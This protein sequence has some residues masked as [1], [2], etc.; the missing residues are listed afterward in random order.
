MGNF[1]VEPSRSLA[2]RSSTLITAPSISQGSCSRLSLIAATWASISGIP[3][4]F[5]YG[6]TLKRSFFKYSRVSQWLEKETPSASW[7]LKTKI[8]SPRLAAIFGSSCRKEPAA[9]FRGLANNGFPSSSRRSFSRWKVFLGI[10]TSP[11]TISREGA[12]SRVM[13]TERM[14]LIFSVTSS[15]TFPSPRVAP[16]TSFPS[17]YSRATDSPS[18]FGSTEN[19]VPGSADSVFSRKSFSSSMLNTSC[20]LMSGTGWATS[21]NWLRTDPPTRLVG[22]SSRA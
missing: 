3:D 22:E 16:R 21:S 18:I 20:R 14:V 9:A 12:F 19:A 11:R 10:Y 1:A 2:E 7:I 13:G 8:S 15:P 17:T 6:I 4:S 5:S